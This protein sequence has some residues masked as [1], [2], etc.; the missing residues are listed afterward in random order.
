MTEKSI[1]LKW[2]SETQTIFCLTA[3]S[4]A[5]LGIVNLPIV[6]IYLTN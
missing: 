1:V 4:I 2:K 5:L 6:Y 3:K